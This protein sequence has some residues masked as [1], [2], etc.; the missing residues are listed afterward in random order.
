MNSDIDKLKLLAAERVDE[1]DNSDFFC[2]TKVANNIN[3]TNNINNINNKNKYEQ[4]STIKRIKTSSDC[5]Q[6]IDLLNSSEDSLTILGQIP[7]ASL[8]SSQTD[9]SVSVKQKFTGNLPDRECRPDLPWKF[10][11]ADLAKNKEGY[12]ATITI[13]KLD[14]EEKKY[15]AKLNTEY[16]FWKRM[17]GDT[18][19]LERIVPEHCAVVE[20]Y[21]KSQTS[22]T[23]WP[24][25]RIS[26]FTKW[27]GRLQDKQVVPGLSTI[28]CWDDSI[29]SGILNVFYKTE[30]YQIALTHTLTAKQVKSNYIGTGM[31][32]KEV[33]SKYKIINIDDEL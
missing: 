18:K 27:T 33:Y 16:K 32:V 8:T 22:K 31:L 24:I 17:E 14:G 19:F 11:K 26:K 28:L 5:N 6:S 29:N 1:R 15:K 30:H 21:W 3:T 2:D 20:Q 13:E 7:L 9:H 10:I 12:V 23:I 25:I 4:I